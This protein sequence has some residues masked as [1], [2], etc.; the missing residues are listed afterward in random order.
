MKINTWFKY[1]KF[2]DFQKYETQEKHTYVFSLLQCSEEAKETPSK[3]RAM[4]V[5]LAY[6]EIRLDQS[7]SR[8][9]I[10]LDIVKKK[11]RLSDAFK[12]AKEFIEWAWGEQENS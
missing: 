7:V 12:H 9:N 6:Y 8:K 11:N 3:T 5:H 1:L 10:S 4:A 2:Q